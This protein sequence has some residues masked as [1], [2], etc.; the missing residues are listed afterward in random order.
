M[1]V[2]IAGQGYVGL[3]LA[4]R[5]AEVGHAVIGY[6]PNEEKVNSLKA[7]NSY[8]GDVSADRLKAA[9]LE[10][11]YLPTTDVNEI[12]NFDIAIITVPTPL[13]DGAPDMS[14]VKE[15]SRLVGQH[16]LPGSTVVLES[17]TYPGTTEELVANI[18]F[19]ESGLKPEEDYFLG[20]SPERIDPGNPQWDFQTTPKVI[21]GIG[22]RSLERI[23]EFY[24]SVC[25]SVVEVSSP[26]VAE[27]TKILENAFRDVN[28][29]FVNEMSV[30]AHEMGIDIWEVIGAAS[31]K[32][33]GFMSFFPG[34][35]VGG[36]CLK[37]DSSYLSWRV[38]SNL[39]KTFRFVELANDVNSHMPDYV[40][41]RATDILNDV[42]KPVRNSKI[43]ILGKAYKAGTADVRE[44]PA[45]KI[46]DQLTAKGALV[47]VSD[48]YI[49]G[50]DGERNYS[51]YD[52]AILVTDHGEFDY[53]IIGNESNL[54]LDCRHKM[55]PADNVIYL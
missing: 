9:M 17:T 41:T 29:G 39:D 14:Y 36:H 44:S 8:V 53:S 38:K 54:I 4:V 21:S 18:I 32:P 6:E 2:V 48:P 20:F 11:G 33:F 49:D 46:I 55:L 26:R 31:T 3:P 47:D 7:G 13:Q 37:I 19:A 5:S 28:I 27:L 42:A 35:G 40:V 16:V 12:A 24:S 50:L 51:A 52:L 30:Y 1:R 45:L 23:K 34:P 25:D 15:A 22:P 10:H 43:L